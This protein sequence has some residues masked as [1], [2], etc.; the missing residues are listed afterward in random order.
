VVDSGDVLNY[1]TRVMKLTCRTLLRQDNW[2][3]WQETEFLQLV[4]YNAQNMFGS[5]VAVESDEVVFNLVWSYRIKA[6]D[7][8]KKACCTCDESTRSGQVRVLDE[9]YANCVDQTSTYLFYGIVANE[10]MIVY[11]ADVSNAFA[12]VP[13]QKIGFLHPSK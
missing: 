11:G 8:C 9:T 7:G 2:Y 1:V 12:E 13:P 5:P 6:V 10:N 3:D 4:Q